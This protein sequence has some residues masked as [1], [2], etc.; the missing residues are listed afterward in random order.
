MNKSTCSMQNKT[1]QISDFSMGGTNFLLETPY[2]GSTIV[3][4]KLSLK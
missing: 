2:T 1:E 4:L 3:L